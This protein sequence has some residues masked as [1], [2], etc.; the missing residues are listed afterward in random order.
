E[1]GSAVR[2]RSP[3]RNVERRKTGCSRR[4]SISCF[5]NASSRSLRSSVSQCTHEISLSWHQALLLPPCERPNSSPAGRLGTPCEG[6]RVARQF[7]CCRS[8]SSLIGES[9][10]GPSAPQF[11]LRLSS[12]PSLLS[13]RLSS[14]CLPL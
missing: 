2:S 11:Q 1:S 8:R 9:S 10:V 4:S 12:V 7:R 5:V 3:V 13:S 14:L 6:N